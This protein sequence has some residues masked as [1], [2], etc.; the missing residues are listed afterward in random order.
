MK[1]FFFLLLMLI[2]MLG[3]AQ[4]FYELRFNYAGET[5]T[6]LMIYNSDEDCSLR[7]V[8]NDML[9]HNEVVESYYVQSYQSMKNTGSANFMMYI[10]VTEEGEYNEGMPAFYWAWTK[11]DA[12]DI[13]QVPYVFF[14]DDDEPFEGEYFAEIALDDMDEEYIA[15]FYSEDEPEY[16]MMLQ[17]AAT[18]REYDDEDDNESDY[19]DAIT[20]NNNNTAAKG[21]QL[22]LIVVANTNVSDIGPACRVD[23]DNVRNEFKGIAKALKLKYDEILIAGNNYGKNPLKKSIDNFKPGSNDVVV[24]VYSGHG[25]RFSDQKDYYPNM[26]LTATSYDNPSEN[27]AAVSDVY[28][29]LS[30]KGARLSIVLSDCCNS[31]L[32][33]NRP[34]VA[35][36]SLFSRSNNSYDLEKLKTLFLKSSG[37][38]IATASSPGEY[39]WC[40]QNGGYFLLSILESLRSQ[41]SVLS[42]TEPNW[43][44]LIRNAISLAAKK[45]SNNK[46]CQTQ[47]GL[48]YV[49]VKKM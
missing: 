4:T 35:S 5:F 10:P 42:K 9:Q 49:K 48:K 8:S 6:G 45:T 32:G 11:N 20:I 34:M 36:N 13:N 17:G 24:F 40:G 31:D 15:Q 43:D 1:R 3:M 14:D 7:L 28:K 21:D 18:V 12:S 16:A 38:L 25:F 2:P 37:N 29:T 41:I 23:M 22:H 47:N 46:D 44:D 33:E 26:D 19:N 39:S 27:Y 30:E